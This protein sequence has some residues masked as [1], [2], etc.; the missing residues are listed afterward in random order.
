MDYHDE[1]WGV[2]NRCS[3]ALFEFLILEGAQAGLSWITVLNKRE[4][5]RLAYDGFDPVKMARY[6]ARKKA[7]LLKNEGIIRNRLKID[8]AIRN[9]RAL[10]ELESGPA[11]FSDYLWSFVDGEPLQNKW[12]SLKQIPAST[13]ISD[14]MSRDLKKKGFNFV[15]TTICYAFM[16]ATGMVNDHLVDCHRYQPCQLAAA[17]AGSVQEQA[18]KGP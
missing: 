15:G 1:E 12:R 11:G 16:Q 10:L 14:V 5:Y 17:D 3:R 18:R 9:A 13:S 7:R 4:N 2:P 8:S 6:D